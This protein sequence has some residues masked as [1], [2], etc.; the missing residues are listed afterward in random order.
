MMVRGTFAQAMAPGV[1]H[2]FLHFLD[3][4]MREEEYSKIFN[5]EDSTQAFEDE[6][7]LAG[8]G[9]MPEKPEG[10]AVVY[11]DMIQGGTKRYT[12]QTYAT[13]SR[14]SWELIEDDQYGIIKQVT[15]PQA[16]AALF[17][18]EPTS[19]NTLTR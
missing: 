1:H 7:E 9:M 18:R 12:H 16:R 14:A 15:K 4:Q 5:L 11:D 19:Y 2:W 6:I 8:T 3:L 13:G 17:A 10:S